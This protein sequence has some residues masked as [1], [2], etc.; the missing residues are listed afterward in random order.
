MNVPAPR[1]ILS[2]FSDTFSWGNCWHS[3]TSLKVVT[4]DTITL[5]I[6]SLSNRSDQ[7]KI[8]FPYIFSAEF[9]WLLVARKSFRLKLDNF[10]RFCQVRVSNSATYSPAPD[11]LMVFNA[12]VNL[13]NLSLC[14]LGGQAARN[15]TPIIP[16]QVRRWYRLR[17]LS[18]TQSV[19]WSLPPAKPG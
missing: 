13:N 19:Q 2:V 18:S 3:L 7:M 14:R 11:P 9:H 4:G 6:H 8:S 5:I 10:R 15:L 12:S 17:F 1:Q 16:L